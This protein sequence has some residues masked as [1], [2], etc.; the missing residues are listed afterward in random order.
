MSASSLFPFSATGH[1]AGDREAFWRHVGRGF[2]GMGVLLL[3][4]TF[5][6]PQLAVI[7]PEWFL[8]LHTAAELVAIVVACIIFLSAWYQRQTAPHRFLMVGWGFLAVAVLDLGHMLSYAGMPDFLTPN[9]PHKAIVLWLFGRYCMVA[10]FCIMVFMPEGTLASA[11][12]RHLAAAAV[13]ASAALVLAVALDPE[14]FPATFIGGEGVTALK[15]A[16]EWGIVAALALMLAVLYRRQAHA[17]WRGD[18]LMLAMAAMIVSELFFTLYRSVTD[19][20]NFLGHLFKVISYGA[21]CRLVFLEAVRV[22]Y[23]RLAAARRQLAEDENFLKSLIRQAPDGVLVTDEAGRIEVANAQV[24]DDFGY[25]A[26][27]LVGKSVDVLL[28][29]QRRPVHAAHR[30]DYWHAPR[31]RSMTKGGVLS[32]RHRDGSEFPVEISLGLAKVGD[33]RR[34][35]AFVRNVAERRR[36]QAEN[37]KLLQLLQESPDWV[38]LIDGELSIEHANPAAIAALGVVPSGGQRLEQYFV[39][40][41]TGTSCTACLEAARTNGSWSGEGL[42][43]ARDGVQVPVSIVVT[44]H[45]Q[46]SGEPLHYAVVARDLTERVRWEKQLTYHATHDALT[47]LPNRLILSDRI[48]RAIPVARRSERLL[49]VLFLDLDNFKLVNDTLGHAAGDELLQAVT[50]RMQAALRQED[51]LTRFGGDEFVV[52][53]PNLENVAGAERVASK[54]LEVL[55]APFAVGGRRLVTKASIGIY[56]GPADEDTAEVMLR[57]ADQAMYRAKRAGRGCYRFF[58]QG[59]DGPAADSVALL[60]ALK[61]AIRPGGPLELHYQPQCRIDDGR[62][63]GVEALLRWTHPELGS[64]S[65][66]R[67]VPLAEE[68]GLIIALGEWVL[69]EACRQAARWSA[70]GVSVKMA[71]NVSVHELRRPDFARWALATLARHGLAP[72]QIEL[73]VTETAVMDTLEVALDN[74][75]ALSEAGVSIA[76]DDFGTG[77][78]SLAYLKTLPVRKL[79]IDRSFVADLAD[80]SNGGHIVQSL[81]SLARSLDLTVIAEGVETEAQRSL[82]AGFGCEQAQGWLFHRALPAERCAEVILAQRSAA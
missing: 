30:A 82:L 45:G 46:H 4:W 2:V 21:L 40:F 3:G 43:V 62:I 8:P 42:V 63:V 56:A 68:S 58:E 20:A 77:Y 81:V 54:L 14:R 13:P 67:I 66:A 38:L 73:E 60:A 26:D 69:D 39:R 9:S 76:L 55:D 32:G 27:E 10:V 74:L 25:R 33:K 36:L 48:E 28:P 12:Q 18:L 15:I 72:A 34:A 16:L 7:P 79:K 57:K 80:G 35:I 31:P 65:P 78:S 61:D 64:I 22:P 75:N 71:V 19:L 5:W 11:G 70:E 59:D 41:G 23:F 37:E 24:L 29:E 49:A 17:A 53:L 44:A 52:V 6:Q 50:R 1:E 47:G 51:T